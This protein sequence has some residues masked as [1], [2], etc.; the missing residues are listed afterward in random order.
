MADKPFSIPSLLAYYA[1]ESNPQS[2]AKGLVLY[3]HGLVSDT[4][5]DQKDGNWIGSVKGLKPGD[6]THVVNFQQAY[7]VNAI[8]S[9]CTCKRMGC[10]HRIAVCYWIDQHTRRDGKPGMP[11]KKPLNLQGTTEA[12][13]TTPSQEAQVKAWAA[14][15]WGSYEATKA[16]V[17]FP[18]M[19]MLLPVIT[20]RFDLVEKRVLDEALRP[21]GIRIASQWQEVVMVSV[22]PENYRGGLVSVTKEGENLHLSC[23]CGMYVRGGVCP[24]KLAAHHVLIKAGVVD[25]WHRLPSMAEA[26]NRE[27]ER[28]GYLASTWQH[29]FNLVPSVSTVQLVPKHPAMLIKPQEPG[30]VPAVLSPT[31]ALARRQSSW[32]AEQVDKAETVQVIRW[33]LIP[34]PITEVIPVLVKKTKTGLGTSGKILSEANLSDYLHLVTELDGEVMRVIKRLPKNYISQ[35]DLY[36]F[37]EDGVT[38]QEPVL[39]NPQLF[40]YEQ[41]LYKVLLKLPELGIVEE[42]LEA[43]TTLKKIRYTTLPAEPSKLRLHLHESSTDYHLRL[44]VETASGNYKHITQ[45]V[46]YGNQL[47]L[48]RGAEPVLHYFDATAL[49]PFWVGFSLPSGWFIPKHQPLAQ[50]FNEVATPLSAHLDIHWTMAKPAKREQVLETGQACL[51]LQ[52]GDDHLTFSP[53]FQYQFL[54]QPFEFDHGGTGK[55]LYL[56]QDGTLVTSYRQAAWETEKIA[57]LQNFHPAFDGQKLPYK[58]PFKDVLAKGWI[59]AL[60]HLAE[61][62]SWLLLG[63]ESFKKFRFSVAKAVT[64]FQQSW[65]VDWLEVKLELQFGKEKVPMKSLRQAVLAGQNYVVLQD[66]SFGMLPEEWLRKVA[67]IIQLGQDDKQGNVK[68][69]RLH[70]H[71]LEERDQQ[72]SFW[73]NVLNRDLNAGEID[74]VEIPSN[75]QAILRPYQH[76]GVSW[77]NHLASNRIGAL[78]ADDMGLGKTIQILTFLSLQH[79]KLNGDEPGEAASSSKGKSQKTQAVSVASTTGARQFLVVVPTSLLFNWQR[80]AARFTPHLKLAVYYGGSRQWGQEQQ[81]ADIVLTTYGIV[82][83]DVEMLSAQHFHTMVLDEAHT[84]KNVETATSK[85]VRMIVAD[86]RIAATGTPVENRTSDLYSQLDFLNPGLLGSYQTFQSRFGQAIDLHGDAER[87]SLLRRLVAPFILRRTK[88]QVAKD[89]P[90]K[91][92]SVLYCELAPAQRLVYNEVKKQFQDEIMSSITAKG[93]TQSQ[94]I[95]LQAIQKLRMLCASAA[96]H[97]PEMARHPEHSAKLELLLTELQGLVKNHKVLVFSNFLDMLHLVE[98]EL[99]HN[100]IGYCYMDGQ[101]RNREQVVQQFKQDEDKRVFLLSLKV[102]GMGL[103]LTEA[104]YVFLLDPWWNPAAESQAIDRTHRIGQEAP[105]MAYRLI[106]LNTIEERML[107][108][109]SRKKAIASDLISTDEQSLTSLSDQEL[110]SLF[111]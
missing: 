93:R 98:D 52:D 58:L 75:I 48:E 111:A 54:G 90:P 84:I 51:F 9:N 31:V 34:R 110:L 73:A 53:V 20:A 68:V 6:E 62:H 102:G 103:N 42:D 15:Y 43:F 8:S 27:A 50:L 85:A 29:Y 66:G 80:E 47:L 105:I 21:D 76:K 38:M 33:V 57:A 5:F 82:R 17:L 12:L 95:I 74:P 22:E 64:T 28:M 109:Q 96:L 106:A 69:S 77:L 44:Q 83:Q 7:D 1:R 18:N 78:L 71:L 37:E 108:L 79:E 35:E 104:E 36:S 70:A 56:D 101:T 41:D 14:K 91:T 94:F 67:P 11:V 45:L 72:T 46:K 4:L 16:K 88:E 49:Q 81:E 99:R 59:M 39:T 107:E 63:Q 60:G 61:Q 97:R 65:G 87:A 24:H 86:Q 100:Q 10:E 92:E 40:R 32:A 19:D 89:L 25:Q 26:A 13:E 23:G 55:I 30:G 2:L 3:H